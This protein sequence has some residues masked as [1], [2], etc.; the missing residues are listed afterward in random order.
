MHFRKIIAFPF[1]LVASL[2][3]AGCASPQVTVHNVQIPKVAYFYKKPTNSE[4]HA[5]KE[6][7]GQLQVGMNRQDMLATLKPIRLL[8]INYHGA[9]AQ[10]TYWLRPGIKITL[11]FTNRDPL[12]V[13]PA[14]LP[15]GEP[16]DTLLDLPTIISVAAGPDVPDPEKSWQTLPVSSLN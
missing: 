7:V 11:H 3:L 2:W 6:L 14:D 9:D 13:V 15:H 10:N 4:L 8:S 5:A 16:D 12:L 1:I